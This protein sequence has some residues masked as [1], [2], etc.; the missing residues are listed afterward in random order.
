MSKVT[1]L[2]VETFE[3]ESPLLCTAIRQAVEQGE[4]RSNFDSFARSVIPNYKT[5]ITYAL[6][7]TVFDYYKAK[8]KED[9]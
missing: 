6:S 8:T 4:T 9:K 3:K 5:S 2:I 1:K 7:L